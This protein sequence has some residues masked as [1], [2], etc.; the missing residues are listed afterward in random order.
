MKNTLSSRNLR[1][2]PTTSSIISK[3]VLDT[4]GVRLSDRHVRRV[5][6]TELKHSF[7]LGI[8]RDI[9]SYASENV[10]YRGDYLKRSLSNYTQFWNPTRPEVF[11]DE[12]YCNEHHV[13]N[14]TWLPVGA[15]VERVAPSGKGRRVCI[16][17]AGVIHYNHVGKKQLVGNWVEGFRHV[18]STQAKNEDYHGNVDSA[19]FENWFYKLCE[20][21]HTHYDPCRIHM[22]GAKYHKR[23][24]NLAPNSNAK[25]E[26]M[27][28]WLLPHEHAQLYAIIKE[29]KADPR[30]A[31]C[32]IAEGFEHEILFTPPYHRSS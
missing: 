12:S 15:K 1:G 10:S 14:L 13:A 26:E 18:W 20:N 24:V 2:L 21:L 22:D 11:L 7:K 28:R 4:T 8:Q 25:K 6:S 5:L 3:G 16:L 29:K 19:L 17:G 32:I 23:N 9:R 27:Q 31:T 30:Y